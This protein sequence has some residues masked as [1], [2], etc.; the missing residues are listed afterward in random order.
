[1]TATP[2]AAGA[3]AARVKGLTKVY[4]GGVRAL[5]GV[6]LEVPA[7][8]IFGLLG[9]NGAGKTT[10][11]KILLGI[12]AR[13]GGEVELLGRPAPDAGVRREV[14]YL[15]EGHRFPLHLTGAEA[16]DYLG[17]LSH[18]PRA[19]RKERAKALLAQ[20]GL[21][22]AAAR[23]LRGYS[24]GMLQRLGLAQALIGDPRLVILDE[25]TDGVDPVGR[26]EIRDLL[27]KMR[28]EGR[29]VIINS[30]ILSELE[31][32]CD[33]V[34][35]LNGGRLAHVGSVEDLVRSRGEWE[36]TVS[37]V[38]PDLGGA[39]AAH[40]EYV[41]PREGGFLVKVKEDAALDRII[42]AVRA[43]GASLRGLAPRKASLEDRVVELLKRETGTAA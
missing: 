22:E 4:G 35:V 38:G 27:L 20:V 14:G 23:K 37:N 11:V 39:I 2:L 31:L 3:P 17:I 15:P 43:S 40:A 21:A 24:K 25:P 29:T 30:H 6:D 13:T 33:R 36:L 10:L 41:L 8:G 16:L 28:S 32:I 5:D 1:V 9:P 19:A 7:G 12:C 34:A 18:V 42:D 26:R